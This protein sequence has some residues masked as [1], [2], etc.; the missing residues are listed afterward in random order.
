MV[1]ESYRPG[2]MSRHDRDVCSGDLGRQVY[3]GLLT[4]KRVPA[5]SMDRLY[6]QSQGEAQFGNFAQGFH[7]GEIEVQAIQVELQGFKSLPLSPVVRKVR[8]ISQPLF[9]LIHVIAFD[10]LHRAPRFRLGT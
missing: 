9:F 7:Q 1:M 3:L 2:D 6:G 4:R 8:Q 5:F 10:R